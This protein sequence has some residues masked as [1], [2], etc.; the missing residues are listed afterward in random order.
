VGVTQTQ[1]ARDLE[2]VTEVTPA[3]TR[4]LDGKS[5]PSRREP[6]LPRQAAIAQAKDVKREHLQERLTQAS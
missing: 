1:V 2:G 6:K 4:G 3:A 5:Y